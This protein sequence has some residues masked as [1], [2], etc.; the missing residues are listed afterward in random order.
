MVFLVAVWVRIH[1]KTEMVL[2]Q[3]N[4]TLADFLL[5][6]AAITGSAEPV[7][8]Q[9]AI[10]S[11]TNTVTPETA[12]TELDAEDYKWIAPEWGSNVETQTFYIATDSGHMCFAQIIHSNPT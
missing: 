10:H 2:F 11:I 3:F 5:R 4:A 9:E 6:V 8:G 12:Y 1:R 7:Y